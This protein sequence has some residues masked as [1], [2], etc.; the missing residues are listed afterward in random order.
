MEDSQLTNTFE[1]EDCTTARIKETGNEHKI[2]AGSTD[3]GHLG[4]AGL[5]SK[6]ILK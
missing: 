2:I 4:D 6:T 1:I 3:D 5:D